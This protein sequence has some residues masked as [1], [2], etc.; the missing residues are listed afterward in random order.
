MTPLHELREV[1]YR[2]RD[3]L[4][5]SPVESGFVVGHWDPSRTNAGGAPAFE[6]LNGEVLY[7]FADE[8]VCDDSVLDDELAEVRS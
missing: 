3:L 2:C 5:G 1:T 8:V 6:P 7:L 4:D